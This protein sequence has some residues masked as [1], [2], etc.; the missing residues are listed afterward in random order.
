MPPEWEFKIVDIKLDLAC[1]VASLG[2]P[3][4]TLHYEL[5]LLGYEFLQALCDDLVLFGAL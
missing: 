2:I 1:L 3:I 4:E 5:F